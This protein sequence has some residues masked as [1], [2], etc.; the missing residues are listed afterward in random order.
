LMD[1]NRRDVEDYLKVQKIP[2]CKDATNR[3]TVYERNKV[4]LHLL[5]LLAKEYNPQIIHA[6]SDLAATAL[7]DYDFISMQA[8]QQFKIL[9]TVSKAKLKLDLKRINDLHPAILR[10]IFRQMAEVLTK[11]P[12]VLDFEHIRMLENLV[13]SKMPGAIDLPHHLKAIKTP[14]FLELSYA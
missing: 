3:Q 4:R 6:L 14:K 13:C 9:V 11:D 8:S 1:L 5:P 12:A 2:F 7:E 10:L